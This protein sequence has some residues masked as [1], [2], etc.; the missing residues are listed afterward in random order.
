MFICQI[1]GNL[2]L[3]SE[4]AIPSQALFSYKEGVETRWQTPSVKE[5]EGIVQTSNPK[6]VAKAMVVKHNRLVPG[7]IPGGPTT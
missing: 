2:L 1:R 3:F 5:D 7:S 4:M 6:G